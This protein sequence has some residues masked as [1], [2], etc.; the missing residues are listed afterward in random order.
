M[1]RILDLLVNC[2]LLNFVVSF[3]VG[4]GIDCFVDGVFVGYM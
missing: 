2:L 4:I 3:F 1:V